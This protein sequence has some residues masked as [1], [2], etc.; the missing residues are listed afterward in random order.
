MRK[1]LLATSVATALIA[2][3]SAL[4]LADDVTV[5]MHAIGKKGMGAVIGTAVLTESNEGTTIAL[6]FGPALPPGPNRFH[7]MQQ[8]SCDFAM[9][10]LGSKEIALLQV[11]MNEDAPDPLKTSVTV[12]GTTMES[13]K[14]HALLILRGG[15]FAD[16]QPGQDP[17]TET[18]ACGVIQ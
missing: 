10:D 11:Q 17:S 1:T 8:N 16:S 6:K 14:G 4:A 9:R 3:G 13:L 12:P 18:V 7:I 2:G 15:Q 5:D